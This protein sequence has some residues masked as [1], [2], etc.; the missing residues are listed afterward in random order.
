M[1]GPLNITPEN[2]NWEHLADGIEWVWRS[3]KMPKLIAMLRTEDVLV[4]FTDSLEH[5]WHSGRMPGMLTAMRT[6]HARLAAGAS[7]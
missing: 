3:G 4:E 6:E 7:S 1:H 5:I 2:V